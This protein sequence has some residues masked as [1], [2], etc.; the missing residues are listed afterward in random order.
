MRNIQEYKRISCPKIE[1]S[2]QLV[3]LNTLQVSQGH[4]WV[5]PNIN[6]WVTWPRTMMARKSNG[7][8]V[9]QAQARWQGDPALGTH[10]ATELLIII[11]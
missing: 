10:S 8:E 4:R 1:W 3:N 11:V 9:A 5:V 7:G 2:I 6:E